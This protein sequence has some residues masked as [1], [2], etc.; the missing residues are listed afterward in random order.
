MDIKVL[1]K[2]PWMGIIGMLI[3][4]GLGFLFEYMTSFYGDIYAISIHGAITLLFLCAFSF[5]KRSVWWGLLFGICLGAGF[6]YPGDI[7]FPQN[8]YL[9]SICGVAAALIGALVGSVSRHFWPVSIKGTASCPVHK[10]KG[11][12][13]ILHIELGEV[14]DTPL[15]G[16][17]ARADVVCPVCRTGFTSGQR[18]RIC[19]ACEVKH[20]RECWTMIGGCSTFGCK[21]APRH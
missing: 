2:S 21:H 4:S 5:L 15:S 19:P 18:A 20:H 9:G 6:S 17:E 8:F 1:T 3:F 7:Y 11:G 13:A 10:R 16:F 14:L 12:E